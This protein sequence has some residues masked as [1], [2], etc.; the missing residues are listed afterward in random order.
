MIHYPTPPYRSR[1]YANARWLGGQMPVTERL[2]AEV[3]SLPMGPHMSIDDVT[4]VVG[5]IREFV[6]PVGPLRRETKS[7]RSER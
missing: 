5:A 2:A 3:L 6:A 1:A 4:R 7:Y